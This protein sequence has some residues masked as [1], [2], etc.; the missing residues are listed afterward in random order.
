MSDDE[1]AAR[2]LLAA[3]TLVKT[4]NKEDETPRHRIVERVRGAAT[5]A[6]QHGVCE[7]YFCHI[8]FE[9]HDRSTGFALE[10]CGHV[11][12]QEGGDSCGGLRGFV[13]SRID[14]GHV[15]MRCFSEEGGCSCQAELSHHDMQALVSEAD[16][17]TPTPTP[18][19]THPNVPDLV[20]HT[21]S[22]T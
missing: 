6:R 15:H 11:Y 16:N 19:P 10:R 21:R 14:E 22:Q 2:P 12:C 13:Q 20:S 3:A 18:T 9:Y 7:T 4:T 17:P 5:L 1:E 8:C